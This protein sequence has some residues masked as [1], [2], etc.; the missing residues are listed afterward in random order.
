MPHDPQRTS[1]SASALAVGI[2]AGR[3]L[4]EVLI[5]DRAGKVLLRHIPSLGLNQPVVPFLLEKRK[6]R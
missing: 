5:A 2:D 1:V 3:E 6:Y 4:L